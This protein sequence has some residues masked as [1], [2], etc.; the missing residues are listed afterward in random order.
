M[1]GSR[2]EPSTGP[3]APHNPPP[4][5]A[6]LL[7][8]EVPL[9]LRQHLIANHE[10]ADSGGAEQWGI[11]VGMELPV[12]AVLLQVGARGGSCQGCSH[13]ISPGEG[14]GT[15]MK[16]VAG[17]PQPCYSPCQPM[18]YGKETSKRLSYLMSSLCMME[19]RPAGECRG[20]APQ[21]G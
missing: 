5:Y 21:T 11:V 16:R 18:E 4:S 17:V 7:R 14:K 6:H 8:C 15:W 9:R 2:D 3:L 12:P 19:A 13:C 10:L 20:V 1:A